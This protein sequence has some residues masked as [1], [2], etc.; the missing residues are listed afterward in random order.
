[1][2]MKH[3]KIIKLSQQRKYNGIIKGIH[4]IQKKAEKEGQI[5]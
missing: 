4:L 1:M 5:G 2:C 3:T